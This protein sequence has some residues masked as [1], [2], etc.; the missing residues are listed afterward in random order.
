MGQR[1]FLDLDHL[2]R[3]V[4]GDPVLRDEILGIFE[5]QADMWLRTLDPK[6]DDQAWRDAAHS[7]KGASRGVGAWDVGHICEQA[8]KLI[9]EKRDDAERV[10]KLQELNEAMTLVIAEVRRLRDL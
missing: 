3:Y 9:G 5:G 1:D 4:A 10:A 2:D 7:L 8:E 6:A